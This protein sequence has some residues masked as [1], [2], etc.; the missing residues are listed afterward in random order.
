MYL[1]GKHAGGSYFN[2]FRK[3]NTGSNREQSSTSFLLSLQ[4]G[5]RESRAPLMLTLKSEYSALYWN[6]I[7]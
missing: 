1:P 4:S 3:D 2:R 5:I 6:E 7:I